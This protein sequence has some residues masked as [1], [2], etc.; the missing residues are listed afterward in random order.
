MCVRRWGRFEGHCHDDDVEVEWSEDQDQP[1]HSCHHKLESAGKWMGGPKWDEGVD[2][3][4]KEEDRSEI[5]W[6]FGVE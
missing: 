1:P 5:Y 2:G 4:E 3:C 6:A